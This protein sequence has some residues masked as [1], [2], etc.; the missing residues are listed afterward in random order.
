MKRAG[1]GALPEGM[2]EDIQR[3]RAGAMYRRL[4]WTPRDAGD[5]R[6]YGVIWSRYEHD[7]RRLRSLPGARVGDTPRNQT[8]ESASG[9]E[10]TA[11]GG[12]DG[13]PVP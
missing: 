1:V 2:L 13:I 11:S 4:S 7:V 9:R 12:D 6:R 8:G 10:R 3:R 5:D